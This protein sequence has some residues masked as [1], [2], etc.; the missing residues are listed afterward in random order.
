[1]RV[2][3]LRLAPLVETRLPLV[4]ALCL[5]GAFAA[6][7]GFLITFWVD[8]SSFADFRS[9]EPSRLYGR[10]LELRTG[11]PI[12]AAELISRLELHGYSRADGEAPLRAGRFVEPR[13]G[14]ILVSI[15]PRPGESESGRLDGR[16]ERLE[17][18]L[19]K[20]T[21]SRLVVGGQDQGAIA[22]DPPLLATFI[23]ADQRDRRPVSLDDVPEDLIRAVLA[24]EDSGF[25]LHG[26]LSIP[27]I[28]RAALANLRAGQVREGASTISQ[29]LARRL[30]LGRERTM[31]RKA[32]E[33]V[34]SVLLEARYSKRRILSAY[35]NEIYLGDSGDAHL[36]GVGAAAHAYFGKSPRRLALHEAALLAGMIRSPGA[37]SPVDHPVEARGRRDRVLRRMAELGWISPARLRNAIDQPLDLSPHPVPHRAEQG[38]FAALAAEEARRRFGATELES[39]GL[40]L[41]STLDVVAQR[42]AEE[43]VRAGLDDLDDPANPTR[44]RAGAPLGELEAAL[45]SLDPA[46]GS[47]RAYVGGRDF[48]ASE[49]DRA[50]RARRPAGSSFKPV[51]LAAALRSGFT[52]ASRVVDS[53]I[54]V[55][56]DRGE[57]RPENDDR[58]F[59]GP[60]SI[61]ESV[62]S[63]LNVPTVRVALATGVPRIEQLARSA[64]F[65]PRSAGPS[66]ALGALEVSPL[67]LAAFYATLASGGLRAE[68]HALDGVRASDGSEHPGRALASPRRVLDEE[69]AYLV[70]ATLRGAIDHGTA[71]AARRLGL[72]DNALAGKTG[73]SD[74]RRDSWFAGY[75]IDRATAV[76]VGFDDNRPTG[77]SGSRGALP[78]WTRFVMAVR[79]NEGYTA[80]KAPRGIVRAKIDPE[81]GL[82]ATPFCPAMREELFSVA[83]APSEYCPWHE[84]S[85]DLALLVDPSAV[86]GGDSA[87]YILTT[88]ETFD[89]RQASNGE[90][91][92]EIRRVLP[93]GRTGILPRP[94]AGSPLPAESATVAP[95]AEIPPDT[96]APR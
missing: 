28:A 90:S 86:A 91:R 68:P 56:L 19:A 76:W 72:R 85:V 94:R 48:A 42:R 57:W 87:G 81:S 15:R 11:E 9:A 24:V 5:G 20:G 2:P 50:S 47:I 46:D 44:R 83:R 71:A 77:L 14:A 29:Q 67:E 8:T 31:T 96:D 53:P 61:R 93:D 39:S 82:L 95:L 26:G 78:I 64:G 63:S 21:V 25:Y 22:L 36:I 34:L 13:E 70:T 75:S 1:M 66:L 41:L 84:P 18:E 23:G 80:P 30:Y 32:R 51:V 60:V 65:S 45:V 88:A 4:V 89:E 62:E 3:R 12:A 27:S 43:A 49:F 52:L 16:E 58:A 7:I 59:R 73:T 37:Y 17:I 54:T 79:P 38:W 55:L 35:L 74:D 69:T 6:L 10:P 33:A 40:V 92:I